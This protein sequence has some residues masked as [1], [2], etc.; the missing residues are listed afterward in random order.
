MA[1]LLGILAIFIFLSP[2]SA[3]MYF[4]RDP[5]SCQIIGDS[6]LYGIGVRAGFYLQWA[7]LLI[8]RNFH[9]DET[10]HSIMT[11]Q[12]M[13]VIAIIINAVAGYRLPGALVTYE[14]TILVLVLSIWFTTSFIILWDFT[15]AIRDKHKHSRRLQ[16]LP[17]MQVPTEGNPIQEQ[18]S[19]YS[20][21][22]GSVPPSDQDQDESPQP[23]LPYTSM[24][25]VDFTQCICMAINFL[26]FSGLFFAL[27]HSPAIDEDKRDCKVWLLGRGFVGIEES[28]QSIGLNE[29]QRQICF[30]VL[31]VVFFVLGIGMSIDILW[32]AVRVLRAAGKT[33]QAPLPT[34]PV[35][36]VLPLAARWAEAGLLAAVGSVLVAMTEYLI[37]MSDI[38]VSV[39]LTQSSGQLIPFVGGILG[40]GVT[41]WGLLE[42]LAVAIRV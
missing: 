40:F 3:Y 22:S 12:I 14:A 4:S 9:L 2:G 30:L 5:G 33:P 39:D 34:E 31:G 7:S 28:D 8:C 37:R 6:D 13:M 18:R 41:L 42:K 17:V 10:A 11:S 15:W 21:G 26:S 36:S 38:D 16:A 23:S 32:E 25:E 19:Q 29:S 1:S 27:R 35:A 20:P 24:R